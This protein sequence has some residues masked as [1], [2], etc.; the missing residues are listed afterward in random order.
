VTRILVVEDDPAVSRML[1]LT[2]SV[3]GFETELLSDG[4]AA[5]ERL[6]GE[7]TDVVVL[8]VMMPH[9]DGFAVLQELRSRPEW[10]ETKVIVSSALRSDEDV[11]KGWSSGADYYLTKPF[12]LDHLRDIVNRLIAG[13][14]VT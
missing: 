11:W 2:F 9:A 12:D 14:P 8:D 7:P 3:E 13:T 6:D 5:V 10:A 4:Q 1:D